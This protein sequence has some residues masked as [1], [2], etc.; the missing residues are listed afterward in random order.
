MQSWNAVGVFCDDF[1]EEARNLHSV[2]GIYPDNINVPKIPGTFARLGMYLRIH[3]KVDA[4]IGEFGIF[5]RLPDGREETLE[6]FGAEFI[7]AEVDKARA[8]GRPTAG[9]IWQTVAQGLTITEPGT[10]QL[11]VRMGGEE[12]IAAVLRVALNPS[13]STASPPPASQS[14]NAP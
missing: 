14:P 13:V 7:R 12:T 11:L 6:G 4:N 9:F 10:I 1:R 8:D 3:V 2:M 5:L